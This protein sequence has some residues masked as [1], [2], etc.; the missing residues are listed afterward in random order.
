[1]DDEMLLFFSSIL[2]KFHLLLRCCA[3]RCHRFCVWC[4]YILLLIFRQQDGFLAFDGLVLIRRRRG[5]V[6]LVGWLELWWFEVGLYC[7]FVVLWRIDF[8]ECVVSCE[9]WWSF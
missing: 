8:V 7:V 3:C 9:G 5:R 4:H 1:M 2:A 6:L